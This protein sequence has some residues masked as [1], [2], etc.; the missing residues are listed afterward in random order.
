METCAESMDE[1][2]MYE[3]RGD[4]ALHMSWQPQR[5]SEFFISASCKGGS[6][7]GAAHVVPWVDAKDPIASSFV[8][9]YIQ[10]KFENILGRTAETLKL[11]QKVWNGTGNSSGQSASNKCICKLHVAEAGKHASVLG[12]IAAML[13]KAASSRLT[14]WHWEMNMQCPHP[15][16]MDWICCSLLG[17]ALL[18]SLMV[19]KACKDAYTTWAS[20]S[21]TLTSTWPADVLPCKAPVKNFNSGIGWCVGFAVSII[22]LQTVAWMALAKKD[23]SDIQIWLIIAFPIIPGVVA[24]Y[25]MCSLLCQKQLADAFMSHGI[26]LTEPST[27]PTY[28]DAFVLIVLM[29]YALGVLVRLGMRSFDSCVLFLPTLAG[30]AWTI[31]KAVMRVRE[32]EAELCCIEADWRWFSEG[33]TDLPQGRAI[34]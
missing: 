3:L 13:P 17:L 25:R 30:P 10:P 14:D 12:R 26:F 8:A 16:F 33:R 1:P 11:C 18:P 28:L 19:L 29:T 7:V 6:D 9:V 5:E 34:P 4:A 23:E 2:N 21:S 22:G 20:G 15:G 31:V 27:R 32:M 24:C